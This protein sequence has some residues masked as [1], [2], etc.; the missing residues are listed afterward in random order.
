MS[1]YPERMVPLAGKPAEILPEQTSYPTECHVTLPSEKDIPFVRS[2]EKRFDAATIT[3]FCND[4]PNAS[5]FQVWECLDGEWML[6]K[7]EECGCIQPPPVPVPPNVYDWEG[8]TTLGTKVLYFCLPELKLKNISFEMMKCISNRTWSVAKRFDSCENVTALCA[9]NP[10]KAVGRN[11]RDWNQVWYRVGT[12]IPYYCSNKMNSKVKMLFVCDIFLRW[13]KIFER[14]CDCDLDPPLSTKNIYREWDGAHS[15]GTVATCFCETNLNSNCLKLLASPSFGTTRQIGNRQ[16]IGSS[17]VYFCNDQPNAAIYRTVVCSG[18]ENWKI[19]LENTC[20]NYECPVQK[21]LNEKHFSTTFNSLPIF[22]QNVNSLGAGIIKSCV[23]N[24]NQFKSM[25]FHQFTICI[26]ETWETILTKSCAQTLPHTECNGAIPKG[27]PGTLLSWPFKD[28]NL[29]ST[30]QYVCAKHESSVVAASF[31]CSDHGKWVSTQSVDPCICQEHP[32]IPKSDLYRITKPKNHYTNSQYFI[33]I[34]CNYS[35][36][37]PLFMIITCSPKLMWNIV[38][39][40]TCT[41][42]QPP[43]AAEYPLTTSWSSKIP[44]FHLGSRV[45]YNCTTDSRAQ[46]AATLECKSKKGIESNNGRNI[47]EL[48]WQLVAYKKCPRTHHANQT[49]KKD[50]VG[51]LGWLHLIHLI[52][53]LK[54]GDKIPVRC[55]PTSKVV[56]SQ[57]VCLSRGEWTAI[58]PLSSDLCKCNQPPPMPPPHVYYYDLTTVKTKEVYYVGSE[59]RYFC[60]HLSE[61]KMIRKAVCSSPS[62]RGDKVWEYSDKNENFRL[63]S[64]HDIQFT[65]L[66]IC[67]KMGDSTHE[68]ESSRS[69]RTSKSKIKYGILLLLCCCLLA[70]IGIGIGYVIAPKAKKSCTAFQNFTNKKAFESSSYHDKLYKVDNV[71]DG[72]LKSCSHTAPDS[73]DKKDT[74]PW[75]YIDLVDQYEILNITY[76]G[77]PDGYEERNHDLQARV[78]NYRIE[79]KGYVFTK[80]SLCEEF[81][82]PNTKKTKIF[83]F[84]CPPNLIGH[85][86]QIQITG[87]CPA[88]CTDNTL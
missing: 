61:S 55:S 27:P 64:K 13:T 15:S 35:P 32:P 36:D 1:N 81:P 44:I 67:I 69:T 87:D 46:M 31:A 49:W 54:S 70:G 18:F 12:L 52:F 42:G 66:V 38:E 45:T 24:S 51:Y 14:S 5:V 28:T 33:F 50:N 26:N 20:V 16:Q 7:Q 57:L 4:L 74:R 23:P 9:H 37:S 80:N 59:R 17:L 86:V 85:F 68:G 62:P 71:Q 11:V 65:F 10:P 29:G 6:D 63:H 53:Y 25:P 56:V 77:R 83:N 34:Y 21:I 19:V 41:C 88:G 47:V 79:G 73:E 58:P 40:S 48:D 8:N 43:P 84:H 2:S 22:R 72:N 39:M 78:G 30:L 76:H 60:S 82:G 3:Y 75:W